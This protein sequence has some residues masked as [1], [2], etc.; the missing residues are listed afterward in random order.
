MEA[1]SSSSTRR[2]LHLA[3]VVA[4]G[5]AAVRITGRRAGIA[6][7]AER[8]Y[9]CVRS[10]STAPCTPATSRPTVS[11][12]PPSPRCREPRRARSTI[13][14]RSTSTKTST[15]TAATAVVSPPP[16]HRRS[17]HH[18]HCRSRRLPTP[19]RRRRRAATI[20]AE[21]QS[22]CSSAAEQAAEL[23]RAAQPSGAPRRAAASAR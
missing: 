20:G 23:P 4:Y 2:Q 8:H 14:R 7:V 1:R 9:A 13:Q 21:Q 10:A 22:S 17:L 11:D 3:C 12:P 5:W 18:H 6:W 16:H 19:P 15:R